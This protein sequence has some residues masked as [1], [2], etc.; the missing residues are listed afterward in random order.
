MASAR[1]MIDF[2][3]KEVQKFDVH[4]F[5]HQYNHNYEVLSHQY[6]D[7]AEVSLEEDASQNDVYEQIEQVRDLCKDLDL[8]DKLSFELICDNL[9]VLITTLAQLNH[10]DLKDYLEQIKTAEI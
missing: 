4:E 10:V 5:I 2:L 1:N 9:R 8:N 6:N 7:L 3:E